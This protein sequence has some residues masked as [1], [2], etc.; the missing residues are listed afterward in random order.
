MYDDTFAIFVDG[1]CFLN[2][3]DTSRRSSSLCV[4]DNSDR[5]EHVELISLQFRSSPKR[6][7]FSFRLRNDA[8]K[9][10]NVSR[11]FIFI[12]WPVC[13]KSHTDVNFSSWKMCTWNWFELVYRHKFISG[14]NTVHIPID[15]VLY[16]RIP[17]IVVH[18]AVLSRKSPVLVCT[19]RILIA[20][21]RVHVANAAPR[22]WSPAIAYGFLV[23]FQGNDE[24]LYFWSKRLV[25]IPWKYCFQCVLWR[26][27]QA[28]TNFGGTICQSILTTAYVIV[29]GDQW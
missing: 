18:V 26:T 8:F 24:I 3:L 22:S 2:G 19:H 11:T 29:V 9:F 5:N 14:F 13:K 16:F 4:I 23:W 12:S 21:C 10:D 25:C 7:E 28:L 1:R 6:F 17:T 15:G 20:I 27:K